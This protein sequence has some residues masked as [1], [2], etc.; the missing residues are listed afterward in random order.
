M[1]YSHATIHDFLQQQTVVSL[2]QDFV[3]RQP[4]DKILKVG[5]LPFI[6]CS[7]LEYYFM[8]PKATHAELAAPEFQ[9]C[10]GTRMHYFEGVG[11]RDIKE[12]ERS[13]ERRELLIETAL[14]EG[15]EELGLDFFNIVGLFEVGTY[16]FISAST[17]K[18]KQ[19][20]MFAAEVISK[21]DFLPD[22]EIAN[23]TAERKWMN[24]TDFEQ[25]GR[26]DHRSI[27]TDI[28]KK[29]ADRFKV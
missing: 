27:V 13:E 26:E 29:L 5:I 12:G 1:T 3:L 19:M 16:N 21:S 22:T 20:W 10:K 8:K 11:W 28:N 14:R 9:I 18:A 6:N 2:V 4:P 15:R 17:G 24:A 25:I 7:G 23:T